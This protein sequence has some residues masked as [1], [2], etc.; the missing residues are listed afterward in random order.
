MRNITSK[1]C[2]NNSSE[3]SRLQPL[4]STWQEEKRE[5]NGKHRKRSRRK[6]QERQVGGMK[7]LRL[8]LL[9]I[10]LGTRSAVEE[11]ISIRQET[12]CMLEIVSVIR[13][14]G[15]SQMEEDANL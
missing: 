2:R 3:D 11:E 5:E 15:R 13:A 10:L 12:D 7:A 1:P 6:R 8:V 4:Q 14:G 9:W